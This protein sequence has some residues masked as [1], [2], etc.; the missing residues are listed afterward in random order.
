[1]FLLQLRFQTELRKNDKNIVPNDI[2]DRYFKMKKKCVGIF[3]THVKK[4]RVLSCFFAIFI[5]GYRHLLIN[6]FWS[7]NTPFFKRISYLVK[8]YNIVKTMK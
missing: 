4:I 6:N 2:F 3:I 7:G 5:E 8:Q 1:M